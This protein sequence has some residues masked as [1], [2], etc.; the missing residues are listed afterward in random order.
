MR[1]NVK[2]KKLIEKKKR[3]NKAEKQKRKKK[4]RKNPFK[5]R[6]KMNTIIDKSV[7]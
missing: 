3:E 1:Q 2:L 5:I 6:N 4:K 7:R